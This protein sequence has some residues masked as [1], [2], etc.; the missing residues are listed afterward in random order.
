MTLKGFIRGPKD[1][2]DLGILQTM[3][4]GLPL[5]LGLGTRMSDPYVHV[6]LWA[7]YGPY[8]ISGL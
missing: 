3:I 8:A 2:I 6:A 1:H 4:S 5:M 7:M